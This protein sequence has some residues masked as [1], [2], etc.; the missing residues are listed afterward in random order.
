MGESTTELREMAQSIKDAAIH[1]LDE[2]NTKDEILE[3]HS[4]AARKFRKYFTQIKN[5][6]LAFRKVVTAG[7]ERLTKITDDHFYKVASFVQ[8][9]SDQT[10][11]LM[12]IW[13]HKTGCPCMVTGEAGLELYDPSGNCAVAVSKEDAAN[14]YTVVGGALERIKGNGSLAA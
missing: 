5:I 3:G 9:Y 14:L 1:A 4:H 7:N 10:D 13:S 6:D 8:Y 12:K 11:R 2:K